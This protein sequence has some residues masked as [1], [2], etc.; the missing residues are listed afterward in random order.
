[1]SRRCASIRS[2]PKISKRHAPISALNRHQ[3]RCSAVSLP[4]KSCFVFIPETKLSIISSKRFVGHHERFCYDPAHTYVTALATLLKRPRA[5]RAP[6]NLFCSSQDILETQI[7]LEWIPSALKNDEF[8]QP[9][10]QGFN[11]RAY[12]P[13]LI[14]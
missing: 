8:D 6:R 7:M 9:L 5:P 10:S 2:G 12:I 11:G 14:A 4:Q 3:I 1:M 13:S